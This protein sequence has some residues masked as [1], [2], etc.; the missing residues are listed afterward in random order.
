ILAA[1]LNIAWAKGPVLVVTFN[2]GGLAT[3]LP[4][5]SPYTKYAIMTNQAIPYN[6]P[7]PLHDDGHMPDVPSH[8][9]GPQSRPGIRQ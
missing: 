8:P 7:V 3:I 9:Q 4:P 2:T 5:L 1:F 6:H